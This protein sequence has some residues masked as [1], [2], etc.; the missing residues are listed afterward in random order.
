MKGLQNARRNGKSDRRGRWLH[1]GDLASMSEEGYYKITGR[2]EG[3]DHPRGENIYPRRSK[4]S[5]TRN[6]Q[7][8]DV[9]VIGVPNE[10]Y[11][12]DRSGRHYP[13]RRRHL[14]EE[15]IRQF[16]AEN[17]FARTRCPSMSNSSIPSR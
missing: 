9:Q 11:G 1:T 8:R 3:H 16:V 4:S 10:K 7:V 6:P 17:V 5:S 13:D 15:E 12:E 2:F 14:T